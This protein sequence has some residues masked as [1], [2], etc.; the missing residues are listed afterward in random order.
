ML[1]GQT[2]DINVD[3]E[4]TNVPDGV[5]TLYIPEA[6]VLL[7]VNNVNYLNSPYYSDPIIIGDTES[8]FKEINKDNQMTGVTVYNLNGVKMLESSDSNAVNNLAKGLYIINGKKVY[9]RK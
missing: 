2:T 6:L 4:G 7:T 1:T 8:V 5:Y 3:I 9:I